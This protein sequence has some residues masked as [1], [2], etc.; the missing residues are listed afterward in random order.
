MHPGVPA[1]RVVEAT[2][3]DLRIAE[4]LTEI[5]APT[6]EGLR[7]PREELDPDRLCLRALRDEDGGG[8]AVRSDEAAAI[9]LTSP[10]NR[11]LVPVA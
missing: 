6:V 3:W 1:A 8:L 5:P 10:P 11:R 9:G 4:E 7:L 2:G